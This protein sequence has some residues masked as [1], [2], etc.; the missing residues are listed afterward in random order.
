M[1]F[2]DLTLPGD[3]DH[4]ISSAIASKRGMPKSV[5]TFDFPSPLNDDSIMSGMEIKQTSKIL[6]S[7]DSLDYSLEV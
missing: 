1:V 2:V 7:I 5:P 3:S 4:V 6:S